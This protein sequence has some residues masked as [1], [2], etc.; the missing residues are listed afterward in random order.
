[1]SCISE[2]VTQVSKEKEL[3]GCSYTCEGARG[4]KNLPVMEEI[5][6]MQV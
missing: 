1:M 2:R 6:G 3:F 4:V 5:Q